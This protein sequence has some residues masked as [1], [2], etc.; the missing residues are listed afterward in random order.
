MLGVVVVVY[1]GR[2]ISRFGSDSQL[3]SGPTSGRIVRQSGLFRFA[4][5]RRSVTQTQSTVRPQLALSR[6]GRSEAA[7]L[8]SIATPE[9]DGGGRLVSSGPTETQSVPSLS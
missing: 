9:S 8:S 7:L 1:N 5:C 4:E 2:V 6:L 3:A